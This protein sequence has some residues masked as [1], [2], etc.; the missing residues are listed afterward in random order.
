MT[1]H[2]NCERLDWLIRKV[3]YLEHRDSDG[4]TAHKAKIGGWWPQA[5]TDHS[6]TFE[7]CHGMPII[8]YID[9]MLDMEKQNEPT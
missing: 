1:A 3:D 9:T 6:A 8:E 7:Q 2:T 4:V 5:E